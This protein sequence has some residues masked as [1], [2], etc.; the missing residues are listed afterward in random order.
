MT[1]PRSEIRNRRTVIESAPPDDAI[2]FRSAQREDY[3]AAIACMPRA[4][5]EPIGDFTV[6]VYDEWLRIPYRIYNPVPS[7]VD[8]SSLSESQALILSCLYTRHCDG[9]VRQRYLHRVLAADEQWAVPFVVAL[10]G[11]YVVEILHDIERNLSELG[12]QG[13]R[14]RRRF[15]RFAEEN[16]SS[17]ALT[18]QR[19]ESYWR[20]YYTHDFCRPNTSGA[21][22]ANRPSYPGFVLIQAIEE[23]GSSLW[24]DA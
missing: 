2:P 20:E 6:R 13:S 3:E 11:E 1:W 17:I 4:T 8:I 23:S 10:V 14:Q 15:G 7:A 5:I 22:P 18:R 12:V 9:H 19:V 21:D 24:R 16:R